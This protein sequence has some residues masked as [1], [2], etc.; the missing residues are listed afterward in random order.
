MYEMGCLNNSPFGEYKTNNRTAKKKEIIFIFIFP[1]TK[2]AAAMPIACKYLLLILLLQACRGNGNKKTGNNSSPLYPEPISV[3]L[4]TIKGYTI[5]LITGDSIKPLLNTFGDTV[6]TG[7]AFPFTGIRIDSTKPVSP[8]ITKAVAPVKTIIKTN[9]HPLPEKIT[10]IPVDV[11]KLKQ[12]KAGKPTVLDVSRKKM[13]F[14]EPVPVK[15]L[16]LRFKDNATA[17]VQYLDVD[18][19]MGASYVYDLVEDKNGNIWL[20]TDGTGISKYNGVTFSH[21]G[22]AEGLSSNTVTCMLPDK[23]G[24]MWIG[25]EDGLNSF[26]GANFTQYQE[27]FSGK[28]FYWIIQDKHSNIWFGT[29]SGLIK[30]D[31]NKFLQYSVKEGLPADNVTAVLED[32]HSNLWF[33]TS[34]GVVKFDGAYFTNYS[35]KDGLPDHG[36]SSLL[37]DEMGN[38]WIGTQQ[39]I[40]KFDGKNFTQYTEKE[41]LSTNLVW[42]MGQDRNSNIW[43]G[44]SFGGMNKFDGKSF[45]HYNLAEGVSNNKIR[46]ILE[47]SNGNIWFGTDGGGINKLNDAG[48][49]YLSQN[50]VLANN[51]VRPIIKDKIG[52]IWFGTEG[53]GIGKYDAENFAGFSENFS[54]F[55]ET[56]NAN[57]SG[58]RAL[59]QDA[60]GSIWIGATIGNIICF[61]GQ[62]FTTFLPENKNWGNTIYDIKQDRQ[63]NIWFAKKLDGISKFDGKYF[64]NYTEMEGLP[65]QKIF[66][67]HEDKKGNLWFGT[68]GGGLSKYDGTR[69]I[70]YTEKEGLF[71]KRVTSILEDKKGNL[72]LGTLGSGVCRFDGKS[73]T[74]YTSKEGLSNNYVWSLIE[75][76]AGHIWAGTDKGLNRL[77]H[78]N[79]RYFIYNYG[80]QDGLKALDFN[81]HSACIDNNNRIWW[82]TGKNIL[83]KDMNR[84]FKQNHVRAVM[85]NY[86][87]INDR[88]YDYKNLPDNFRKKI[89][90]SNV[91]AFSN[92]PNDLSVSYDQDHFTFHFSA[93]DWS[94]P[95]KIKYSYR[96]IGLDDNWSRPADEPVADYRNLSYG[97]YQFQV[98]AIG[99]SQVWTEPYTYNFTIR[100]AW[101]QTWWFKTCVILVIL[102]M[103]FFIG[104][105][106]Y[107]YQLRKQQIVMEKQLAIELERQRISAEMHDDI[108]A[109]LSGIR[110]LTEITKHKVKDEQAAAEVE[111]IYQSVGDI[112]SKMKEVIWSLNTENDDLQNL[113]SYLHKQA[114]QMMENFSGKFNITLPSNIPEAKISGEDRRHIYLAVKEALHNIIKHSGADTVAMIITCDE[115]LRIIISDNGKGMNNGSGT[116]NGIKNM[117]QRIKQLGGDFLIKNEDGLTITFQI[118]FKTTL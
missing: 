33:G 54:Y 87:E 106:I 80:L 93:I 59:M 62:I 108:G 107:F 82:G 25:T 1:L 61:K 104:R 38:I 36:I 83:I 71:A 42:T 88:F 110:L 15:A 65:C 44:T 69:L 101:W 70:N 8:L 53:G 105:F 22:K 100:P 40:I 18:Q 79:N 55:H 111:K 86:V 94:A 99:Q 26:D 29:S 12:V 103:L 89:S 39:G 49:S 37:E 35:K 7:I 84:P 21:Y 10:V 17:N 97:K 90:F 102:A 41:G 11:T 28:K 56:G 31:G 76:S 16:P 52:N 118:P 63:G 58:Q 68:E 112:S 27:A 85:L 91:T 109:G 45:T 14:R 98:K 2:S 72:L 43:I 19:G 50:E 57:F 24:C 9:V 60:T 6:K 96:I 20:G 114:R 34:H 92:C 67:I 4:D 74:Y 47:D 46:A 78:R 66:A 32:K 77:I 117:Q 116:G 3:V 48:F 95:D 13:P 115:I 51:R 73:F 64:T 30:H 113:I 75:D 5:N 23:S 81:L